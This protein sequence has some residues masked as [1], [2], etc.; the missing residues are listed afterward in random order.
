MALSRYQEA[1]AALPTD[2]RLAVEAVFNGWAADAALNQVG[3]NISNETALAIS[4]FVSLLGSFAVELAKG[5]SA[6]DSWVAA[7]GAH[8]WKGRQ[9]PHTDCP[10]ILGRA[11]SLEDHANSVSKASSGALTPSKAKRLLL[12]HS[13]RAV[14][15]WLVPFLRAAPLGNFLI[16]ATFN[17]ND[18]ANSPFDRLPPSH[19][20]ICT[21]LA[22]GSADAS[23]I[24]LVWSHA[25]CGS[26]RLHR[27][28]VADAE[29]NPC[30][31]GLI[32]MLLCPGASR[33]RCRPIR[34]PSSHNRSWSCRRQPAGDCAFPFGSFRLRVLWP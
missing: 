19:V 29:D 3:Q 9:L 14:P 4:D 2:S 30:A 25:G 32:P 23:L 1:L 33:A 24:L 26:P 10:S 21:A 22:L 31:T 18:P 27:P 12:K 20:G 34:T 17:S 6:R 28:T 16:W 8:K 7:C 13:G 11:R 5:S 15:P